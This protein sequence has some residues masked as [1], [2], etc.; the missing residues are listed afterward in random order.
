VAF[1]SK[2]ATFQCTQKE[3]ADSENALQTILL[4]PFRAA[5]SLGNR[6]L[7][8]S[9]QNHKIRVPPEKQFRFTVRKIGRKRNPP[10]PARRQCRQYSPSELIRNSTD[11]LWAILCMEGESREAFCGL[12]SSAARRRGKGFLAPRFGEFVIEP[13]QSVCPRSRF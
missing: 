10:H 11:A 4:A 3:C 8:R 5:V 7:N 2:R 12:I 1:S 6:S 13:Q 9:E